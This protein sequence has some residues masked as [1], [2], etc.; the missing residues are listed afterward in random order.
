[1]VLVRFKPRLP[2]AQVPYA[3]T[4]SGCFR[5]CKRIRE[6]GSASIRGEVKYRL[7]IIE[8]CLRVIF[9]WLYLIHFCR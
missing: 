3:Q 9:E 7:W 2:S 6:R 8:T 1:M 4:T 5:F